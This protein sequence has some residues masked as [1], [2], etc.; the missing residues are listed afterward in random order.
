MVLG[1]L[2]GAKVCVFSEQILTP[3]A[4]LISVCFLFLHFLKSTSTHSFVFPSQ[5]ALLEPPLIFPH[6]FYF[7]DQ[8]HTLIL[9]IV[10][11]DYARVL[12]SDKGEASSTCWWLFHGGVTVSPLRAAMLLSAVSSEQSSSWGR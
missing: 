12:S 1:A 8:S 6:H 5:P 9:A 4:A 11:C 3:S 10:I 7:L 2:A